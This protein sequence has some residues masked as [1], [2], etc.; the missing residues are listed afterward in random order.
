[1]TNR[2]KTPT[3]TWELYNLA[4]DHTET[5]NLAATRPDKLRELEAAWSALNARMADPLF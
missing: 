4:N 5:T 2:S 1:M 3:R